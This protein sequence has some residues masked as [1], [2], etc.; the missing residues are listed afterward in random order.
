MSAFA[1]IIEGLEVPY[2]S[3]SS[4]NNGELVNPALRPHRCS[5]HR[6]SLTISL[7]WERRPAFIVVWAFSAHGMHIAAITTLATTGASPSPLCVCL[8]LR[9]R[10]RSADSPVA[11]CHWKK[12][13]DKLVRR[14]F[15]LPARRKKRWHYEMK[16]LQKYHAFGNIVDVRAAMKD[17]PGNW[18]TL[19]PRSIQKAS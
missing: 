3:G 4:R 10:P 18:S 8:P 15:Y 1:M 5:R 7:R 2:R 17:L 16:I 6:T 11:V 13:L 9:S 19:G 12:H 14:I